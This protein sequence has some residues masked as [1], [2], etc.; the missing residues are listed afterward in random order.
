MLGIIILRYQNHKG[1]NSKKICKS[2]VTEKKRNG[3]MWPICMARE[4]T[5]WHRQHGLLHGRDEGLPKLNS[6]LKSI[7]ESLISYDPLKMIDIFA[8][9]VGSDMKVIS[10]SLYFL[11]FLHF[12]KIANSIGG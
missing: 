2:N 7:N 6:N 5:L 12:S 11:N 1:D 9:G 10:L 3:V 8:K 4:M